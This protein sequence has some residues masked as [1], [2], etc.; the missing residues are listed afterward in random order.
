MILNNVFHTDYKNHDH[1]PFSSP[2]FPYVCIHSNLE[3]YSDRCV[4]WHWH[5]SLEIA[6]V[7][8]GTIE[9]K[10]P[11]HTILLEAGDTVFVN[12][13]VLHTYKAHGK[14]P[15]VQHAHLFHMDFLS[16][17]ERSVFEEKYMLPVTRCTALQAWRIHPDTRRRMEMSAAAL[18]AADLAKEEREGYEFD[19]RTQLSTFWRGLLEETK[20]VRMAAPVRNTADAE[21]IKLM[22]DFVRDHYTESI[23]VEDIAASAG[24]STRECTR[25]FRRSIGTSPVEHLSQFRVR[26][27]AKALR[28]TTKTVLEISEECGFSSPSYFSKVF[29][30][31]TGRTPREYQKMLESSGN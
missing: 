4:P 13:G 3:L 9:V 15:A 20:E 30:D 11:D 19:I 14:D 27:A 6:T 5:T 12:T 29:R 25:C 22:M 18:T 16:G 2:G 8:S 23:T 26:M 7:I 10:T 31:L 17:A 24:I 21:R 28:E 1:I